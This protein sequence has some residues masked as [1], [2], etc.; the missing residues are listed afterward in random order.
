MRALLIPLG[1]D[2][3]AIDMTVVREV[4]AAPRATQLPTGP[5]NALGVFNL[6]GEIVPLFDTASMLGLRAAGPAAFAVV[7]ESAMGLAGLAATAAPESAELGT[8]LAATDAT[9]TSELY[10]VGD[11]VVALLD[12]DSLLAPARIG[13]NG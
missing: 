10:A 6:R 1:E 8:A 9:A 13:A 4:V 2:L 5:P 7:I 3:Y 12:A 11:R